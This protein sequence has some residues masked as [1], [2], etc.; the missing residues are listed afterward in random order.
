[1]PNFTLY[2]DE[3]G[4]HYLQNSFYSIIPTHFVSREESLDKHAQFMS[5]F[6]VPETWKGCWDMCLPC[7]RYLTWNST[8]ITVGSFSKPRNAFAATIMW[9]NKEQILS[10]QLLLSKE[11]SF[12]HR[13]DQITSKVLHCEKVIGIQTI[14]KFRIHRI[15][16]MNDI[17]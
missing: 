13:K 12:F 5:F 16:L 9:K 7:F 15:T 1:M 10:A 8:A 6:P 3:T 17:K 14:R 11:F 4:K 2:H